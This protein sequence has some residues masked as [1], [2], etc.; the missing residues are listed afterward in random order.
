MRRGAFRS[1]AR[2][3]SP[4]RIASDWVLARAL[5]VAIALPVANLVTSVILNTPAAGLYS[6][7]ACLSLLLFADFRGPMR[8][9]A[10]A[11]LAAGAGGAGATLLGHAVA[12]WPPLAAVAGVAVGSLIAFVT[13]LRG[14]IGAGAA[15][16]QLGFILAA[17]AGP[18]A[19]LSAQLLGWVVGTLV[20]TLAALTLWPARE[21]SQF[22]LAVADT[23]RT[24][25]D[26]VVAR[27]LDGDPEAALD[28]LRASSAAL[29]A[30]MAGRMNR[31]G[32]ATSR[33]RSIVELVDELQRLRSLLVWR[34]D[35]ADLASDLDQALARA[36]ATTLR[37][38]A[39]CLAGVG[40][41]PDP[42]RIAHARDEHFNRA[43]LR[44]TGRIATGDIVEM[45]R[46]V[47]ASFPLRLAAISTQFIAEDTRGA[48]LLARQP[49]RSAEGRTLPSTIWEAGPLAMLR[50]N[51]TLASPWLRN[52]LRA[53]LGLG[54]AILIALESNQESAFWVVLGTLSVLRFDA[55]GTG[56][57]AAQAVL[58]TVG[59]AVVG[60]ALAEA[61]GPRPLLLWLVLPV[62]A[63]AAAY[64]PTT[65]S[66]VVAQGA[67]SMFLI[68]LT[69]LGTGRSPVATGLTRITDIALGAAVSVLV[70][71]LLW[72]RGVLAQV[73]VTLADM[74]VAAGQFAL[75]TT[76]HLAA[77][78]AGHDEPAVP[79][80][81][82]AAAVAAAARADE[83]V[84]L[85]GATAGPEAI[86]SV[87]WARI[88]SSGHHFIEA[89]DVMAALTDPV[90]V[91]PGTDRVGQAMR[92]LAIEA[93]ETL[94]GAADHLRDGQAADSGTE[95]PAIP[96][97]VAGSYPKVT[98]LNAHLVAALEQ[99]VPPDQSPSDRPDGG[100]APEPSAITAGGAQAMAAIRL[101]WAAQWQVYLAWSAQ[102]VADA[103]GPSAPTT[104][105]GPRSTAG[106]G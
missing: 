72:P 102:I 30:L 54:L 7:F 24:A 21:R 60:T 83:A 50:A 10:L 3:T 52:G 49:V 90:P 11:Y 82:R 51:S 91:G 53:G 37:E 73:R 86:D 4:V 12:P 57:T 88:A 26:L 44:A 18:A 100:G 48:V 8:S 66:F 97:T 39:D 13:L 47:R 36:L 29:R 59:G 31:P 58:G 25:A 99:W 17:T 94:A 77:G 1:P 19:Q 28:R 89:S 79:P 65:T 74:L 61:I 92:E 45:T 2:Q 93:V 69:T 43:A 20:A 32:G 103:T 96:G 6:G 104:G 16:V 46:R 42:D 62:V 56:R 9:R 40:P 84:D 38:S 106:G 80:Q 23:V 105:A 5:R 101:I 75:A 70:G 85:A 76:E 95:L 87:R 41:P 15:T 78:L 68:I 27:Y 64:T 81:L 14:Y 98:L 35:R 63:F 34:A 67:F 22:L 71:F 33:D 55:L